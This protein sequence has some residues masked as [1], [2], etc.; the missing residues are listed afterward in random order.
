MKNIKI[1][2]LNIQYQ[3][4]IVL[5]NFNASFGKGIHWIQGLNGSGKSSLLK[6]LCGIVPVTNNVVSIMGYDLNTQAIKA[7]SQ[8]CF[9]ADKPEV[10]PFMSGIG[11]LKLLARIKGVKLSDE[12]FKFMDAINL[13]PYKDINFSEMSFGTRRKFTLCSVFIGN[14]QVILLDEP[15]NGLDKT[16][17]ELFRLWLLKARNEKCLLIV[18]HD[19]HMLDNI[20][21]NI[22]VLDD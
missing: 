10:Y 9:V 15:F 16:T 2:N 20:H 14:P 6:S 17:T 8:L 18:S 1:K 11:F 4:L 5:Q 3:D 21:K 12:L 22:I 19:T 13:T 7:K